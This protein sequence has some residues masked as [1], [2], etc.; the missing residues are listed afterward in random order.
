[1]R[2]RQDM[3]IVCDHFSQ[4]DMPVARLPE[5]I[6]KIVVDDFFGACCCQINCICRAGDIPKQA[7]EE[8]QIPEHIRKDREI[9]LHV[10]QEA[11]LNALISKTLGIYDGIL[12]DQAD[13]PTNT[14]AV[15]DL[16]KMHQDTFD[17]KF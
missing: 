9:D 11:L 15:Y 1:M 14:K 3:L 8:A 10:E 4:M 12:F 17:S 7:K 6:V 5:K 2:Y 16:L 13:Y